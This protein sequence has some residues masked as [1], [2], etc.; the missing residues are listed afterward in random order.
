MGNHVRTIERNIRD[1][2]A[3]YLE[4]KTASNELQAASGGVSSKQKA[5]RLSP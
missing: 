5:R 2:E 1:A 3:Q 4:A